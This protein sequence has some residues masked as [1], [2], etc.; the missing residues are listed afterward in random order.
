[1]GL[2]NGI[3]VRGVKRKDLPRFMRYPFEQDYNN[4]VEIC[5]WRKWWG[6]RNQFL[7][8]AFPNYNSNQYEFRLTEKNVAYMWSI[9]NNYLKYP[10]DWD[11][12]YWEYDRHIR[13]ILY[14]QKWNLTLLRWWMQRHPDV[15]VIF[16]DSY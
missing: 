14:E 11:N 16:Y 5:Y 8:G 12:E 7:C 10:G 6:L 9:V 3:I 4:G 13:Q 15:E 2:D 1:M